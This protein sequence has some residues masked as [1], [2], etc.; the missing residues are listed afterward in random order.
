MWSTVAD[1]DMR[2]VIAAVELAAAV[3]KENAGRD[4]EMHDGGARELLMQVKFYQAGAAGVLPEEWAAY[5]RHAD[6][7]WETYQR[8]R[9]KFGGM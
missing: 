3:K 7:D 1:V 4:G 8:L 5:A 6:P 9:R 2:V